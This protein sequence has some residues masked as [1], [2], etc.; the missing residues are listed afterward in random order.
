MSDPF[1][2]VPVMTIVKHSFSVSTQCELDTSYFLDVFTYYMPHRWDLADQL[3]SHLLD[4]Y[5]ASHLES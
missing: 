3:R 2:P 4:A 5:A 1:T